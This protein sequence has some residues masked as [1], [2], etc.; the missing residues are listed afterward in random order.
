MSMHER[1]ARRVVL[2]HAIEAGDSQGRLLGQA[3]RDQIDAQAREA[4][5]PR[6]AVD[7]VIA[8]ERFL[9]LRA[10]R[11][12]AAVEARHPSLAA[13]QDPDS[14]HR[15][16]KIGLPLGAVALGV[17]T[18]V[19][20]NP[21]RV[22]L[23]SLP[24]LA[25]VA[26]NLLM[27]AALL[28][29]WVVWGRR[30]PQVAAQAQR[31]RVESLMRWRGGGARAGAQA[32][33]FFHLRWQRATQALAV[34]RA[35]QVLH[36][37]AAG[38]AVGVALSLLARGLVVEYRV[39]W[40]STFLEAGQVHAILSLVRLPA[41]LLF[42][43]EPFSVPEVASLQFSRGGGAAGGARWVLMYVALLAVVV[44]V[45]RLVLAA[46]A[47]WR[48]RVAARHVPIDVQDPYYRRVL[49]L[50]SAVR[51][52]LCLVTHRDADRHALMR[53]L[54]QEPASAD[55]LI[56]S[57]QDDVLQLLDL[58][59]RPPPPP[60]AAG[61]WLARWRHGW[62]SRR[63]PGRPEAADPVLAVA[64][65]EC[66]VVLH[67]VRESADLD[68]AAPLLRWLDKPVLVLADP[69]RT[70]TGPPP[71]LAPAGIDRAR[72]D[73]QVA[74]VLT[75]GEFGRCWVQE[76]V[77]LAAIG[78]CVPQAEGP[79]FERIVAAWRQRSD[80]RLHQA[81]TVVAEHLLYSARQ[82]Q[83]VPASALS[84]RSLLPAERQAQALARQA[85]TD[86]MVRRLDVSAGR[87]FAR[88]CELHGVPADDAPA[89]QHR[90]Q[91]RFVVQQPVEGR[92]AGVAGA[93]TGAAV[94]ASVD[95]L[96]GGL[97]L[98]AAAAL[99][100]LVGGGAGYLAAAWKNRATPGGA[101]VVQ[102]SDDML[103]ALAE[104]ALLRYQAVVHHGRGAD[105]LPPAWAAEVVA[106]A[107]AHG[108]QLASFW[109]AARSQ[110][111]PARLTSAVAREL[112]GVVRQVL[113]AWYPPR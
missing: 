89:L 22:D 84:V 92:Q 85:A 87:M 31:R 21:H 63:D 59:G 68:A 49:S 103:Q 45:P 72:R 41:L 55:T 52:H 10:Q 102:L 48:E 50:L 15:W 8:P 81:M 42:P 86:D 90:L 44:V 36:L 6:G 107:Q 110:P 26:W 24:L 88:L 54:A 14:W 43:F 76:P 65:R 30:R 46:W 62:P 101:T 104:A 51:V 33:A 80:L 19:V 25:I 111:D 106:A 97:T 112:E 70:D 27:Y 96:V 66:D 34:L 94:G 73:P 17:L 71:A 9:D 29:G 39:G 100:A 2:A 13:L 93:A 40:E 7:P 28:L 47:H 1:A 98:G 35:K 78:R 105:G 64:S 99:G 79:G 5:L 82:S 16:L 11:V 91:D 67:V 108:E 53:V 4:A 57:P 23:V 69:P 61:G 32:A 58:S 83:E 18:D 3:E 109:P 77:L 38:W 37:A 56:R 113:D 20:A 60:E 95:L 74:G 75:F 12:I